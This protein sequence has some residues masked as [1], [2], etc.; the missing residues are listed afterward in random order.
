MD[1][2]IS[3]ESTGPT[4]LNELVIER[5][6]T[7]FPIT[8]ETLRE[9]LKSNEFDNLGA[10]YNLLVD[11][12]ETAKTN[13]P[14]MQTLPGDYLPDGAHQLEK[15]NANLIPLFLIFKIDFQD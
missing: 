8:K 7:L 6:C 3:P 15:V 4:Q 10:I 12:L 11:R 14:N 1:F 5:M 2:R 13:L 9:V